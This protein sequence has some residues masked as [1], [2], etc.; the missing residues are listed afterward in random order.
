MDSKLIQKKIPLDSKVK[1]VYKNGTE[2]LGVLSEIGKDYITLEGENNSSITISTEMIGA[3]EIISVEDE[4]IIDKNENINSANT[5]PNSYDGSIINKI[6]EIEA[7]FIS[8]IKTTN[9]DIKP[10]D[11]QIPLD[12]FTHNKNEVSKTLNRAKNKFDNLTKINEL[13]TKFGRIQPIINEIKDLYKKYPF[14]TDLLRI[15]TYLLY[16]SGQTQEGL[17]NYRDLAFRTNNNEDWYNTSVLA[18]ELGNELLACYAFENYFE[19]SSLSNNSNS[20]YKYINLVL[21]FNNYNV[22]N[23]FLDKYNNDQKDLDLLF[24]TFIYFLK[25]NDYNELAY[26]AIQEGLE[27]KD[28]VLIVKEFLPK[29][30]ILPDQ[31]YLDFVGK[32]ENKKKN[33]KLITTNLNSVKQTEGKIVTY[34]KDRNF[35]FIRDNQ[36]KSFF[37]HKSAVIDD[38]LKN[39]LFQISYEHN[40]NIPVIFDTIEGPKGLLAVKINKNRTEKELFSLANDLALNGDYSKAIAQIKILLSK[41]PNNHEASRLYEKWKEFARVQGVP[42]GSNPYAKARRIHLVEKNLAQAEEYYLEAISKDDN[43]ESAIKDLAQ[44]YL[45]IDKIEKSVDIITKYKKQFLNSES[46]DNLLITIYEKGEKYSE[47]IKLL[48]QRL[49]KSKNKNDN[50][51]IYNKIAQLYLKSKN[52]VESEKIFIE[53]IKLQ[54]DNLPAKRNLASCIFNQGRKDEAKR[55]LDE[56][57]ITQTDS[58]TLELLELFNQTEDDDQLK[59]SEIIIETSLSDFSDRIG[60]FTEYYLD[61]CDLQG[62]PPDKIKNSNFSQQDIKKLEQLANRVGAGR[63]DDRANYYLSAAKLS[64]LVD[65]ENLDQ[66]YRYLC[67]SFT[68]KGDSAIN[69]NIKTDVARCW[70]S[71]ALSLYDN[72]YNKVRSEDIDVHYALVRYILSTLG[73]QNVSL[74][75]EIK[76]IEYAIEQVI[77]T[78][79]DVNKLFDYFASLILQS[80]FA[81]QHIMKG[82]HG[83]NTLL[84]FAQD[85]LRNQGIIIPAQI[86]NFDEFVKLWNDLH[87]KKFQEYQKLLNEFCIIDKFEVKTYFLEE[88]IKRIQEVVKNLLFDLDQNRVESL[89]NILKI[90]LDLSKQQ[91]FE[92]K[93]RLCIQVNSLCKNLLSEIQLNPTKI[94]IENLYFRIEKINQKVENYLEDL[95]KT[96]KPNINTKLAIESYIPDDNNEIE[97]QVLITNNTGCSPA[98]SLEIVIQED[99][100]YFT[101]KKTEN[102]M[103][104]SLKGGDQKIILIPLQIT[105]EAISDQTFSFSFYIEYKTRSDEL[106][107]HANS[108]SVRLYSENDFEEIINPFACYAEGGPVNNTDMFYGRGELIDNTY[109]TLNESRIQSKCIVIYGQKRAGKSSILYHLKLLLEKNPEMLVI[110]LGNIGSFLD[111][112]SEIPLL[113]QILWQILSELRESIVSKEELGHRKLCITDIKDIVF[114][115]HPTPLPFFKEQF[116]N[117]LKVMKN[118]EDWN[119]YRIVLLIDEFSYIYNLIQSGK[120]QDSFMKNWKALLQENLFNA[121]LVGQDVMPKFKQHYPNEFGITQD[122][123]VSYI[124][125]EDAKKLIDNPIKINGETRYREKAIDRIIELT[126]ASPFYIQIICN[127]LV[128]Y[129]NRKRILYVT[130]ADIDQ[131]K[132]ELISGV[133]ALTLDKFDNLISSGDNSDQ[134]ISDKDIIKVLR[135]ISENSINTICGKSEIDC[136]TDSNLDIILEDLVKRDVIEREREQYFKIKVGLFKEWLLQN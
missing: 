87:K 44:L 116:K 77:N 23:K 41:D 25:V 127:R 57:L 59:S 48:N 128:E 114:Y 120:L 6:V 132:N 125:Y 76:D 63:P 102:K 18:L 64:S 32:F 121:V 4:D 111:D 39:E 136:E 29:I 131:V 5:V 107:Q 99:E 7:N 96:S 33:E 58:K 3:W 17:L 95:Y 12:D 45:Q 89:K 98:E 106:E 73:R 103:E 123:R 71:V 122:E 50:I 1:F 62:V 51:K 86:N 34:K 43:K 38:F 46:F 101:L 47:A 94:S 65:S 105:S 13:S 82:L 37:F 119:R 49:E 66:F 56:I 15:L 81:A 97:L 42:S 75:P 20:W 40:V 27:N 55:V 14:S 19:N 91:N 28:K 80:K 110:D 124:R 21:K 60:S 2:V 68:S 113:Y 11:F 52:Y 72:V 130:E 84:A 22:L 90:C 10:I 35:G 126:S 69:S 70:Y 112:N 104:E 108:A 115:K 54:P 67:R 30:K 129:M 134:S 24:D 92:E 9:L 61:K 117:I 8:K 36:G 133:N 135:K 26:Q 85:Y 100:N 83:K 78:H 79:P 109:N 93:E 118:N 74:S 53:I 88:S 16:I 31:N